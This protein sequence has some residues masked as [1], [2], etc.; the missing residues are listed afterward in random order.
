MSLITSKTTYL[1]VKVVLIYF[2]DDFLTYLNYES[3]DINSLDRNELLLTRIVANEISSIN[4]NILYAIHLVMIKQNICL[5][6]L[7][8]KI[9]KSYHSSLFRKYFGLTRGLA[10]GH[11]KIEK[12]RDLTIKN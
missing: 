11:S 10:T 8:I 12:Q 9:I 5:R 3:K 6:M 2:Y 4:L 7:R 1:I